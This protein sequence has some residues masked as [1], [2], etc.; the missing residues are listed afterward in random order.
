MASRQRQKRSRGFLAFFSH[1]SGGTGF[2]PAAACSVKVTYR[3][4]RSVAQCRLKRWESTPL[5]NV[6]DECALGHRLCR[7]KCALFHPLSTTWVW[8]SSPATLS[9]NFLL[10]ILSLQRAAPKMPPFPFNQT[11]PTRI[12]H[13]AVCLFVRFFCATGPQA[14]SQR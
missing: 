11:P 6:M 2:E 8:V 10:I 1:V 7:Q 3:G 5:R 9:R 12:T 14:S 13:H 4:V